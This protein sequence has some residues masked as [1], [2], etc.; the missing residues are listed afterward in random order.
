MQITDSTVQDGWSQ[1]S[2]VREKWGPNPSDAALIGQ[3]EPKK[4]ILGDRSNV[5]DIDL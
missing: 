4:Q 3:C 5:L 2:T 1:A